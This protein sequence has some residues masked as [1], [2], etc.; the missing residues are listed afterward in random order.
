MCA[1][2]KL[3]GSHSGCL[4][5]KEY[6][7]T[8]EVSSASVATPDGKVVMSGGQPRTFDTA[9]GAVVDTEVGVAGPAGRTRVVGLVPC[10]F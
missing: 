1:G 3:S 2:L 5:L 9:R 4:T 10:G 8:A 6:E 7:A